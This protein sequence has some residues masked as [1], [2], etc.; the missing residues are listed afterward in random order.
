MKLEKT[1]A[2]SIKGKLKTV[3]SNLG[4]VS[5]HAI[6]TL[7][8]LEKGEI[9]LNQAKVAQRLIADSIRAELGKAMVDN[10]IL[11]LDE[12][13]TITIEPS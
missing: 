8:R 7:D 6:K 3:S 10:Q 12:V 9:T 1:K 5:A 2:K 11:T 13:K 4:K